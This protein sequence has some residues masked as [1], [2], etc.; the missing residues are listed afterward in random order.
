MGTIAVNNTAANRAIADTG[1]RAEEGRK[2]INAAFT[3]IGTAAGKIAKG[4]GIAGMAL[5]GAWIAAVEGTREYRTQMGMLD[6]AFQTAGHSSEAAKKTY[7]DLNAVLGDSAQ[8]TEAAQHLAK[9]T[10]NEKELQ[11]WTNI[12]TGVFATFGEALPIEGLTEAANETAKTGELTGSLV[13][14]LNWAGIGE[15]EFQKKLD[16]CTNEQQ[17]QKLIM[18]TLNGTYSKASEQYK[19]T[20]K[21]VLAANKAQEKLT[22][23][24]AE[25]G[26]VGEPILTV[27]KEKV[28]EMAT[29]AIP[30]LENFIQKVKDGAKWVKDNQDTIHTWV[31]VILGAGVAIGTFLLILNWGTIMTTAAN[32]IKVVRT[33]ILAMNAAML[34]NPIALIVAAIAGLVVGFIY[35]W[36]N[37]EGFR[38]FW[39]KTWEVIKQAASA[40]WD[41]IVLVFKLAWTG[42]KAYWSFA[43]G[44]YKGIWTGITKIFSVVKS[45]F[46][47]R[48]RDAWNG[49][50][51]IWNSTTSFFRGIWSKITGVFGNVG[52]WFRSK[53]AS[54][55]TSIKGVFS[56]WGS[57]FG[58]L[59]TKIKDKFSGLG[60]SLGNA[61]STSVKSA[62][63][64]VLGKVETAINKGIGLINS[65][66]D[67]VPG[68]FVGKVS[69]ITLPRLYRGGVLEKGQMGLLEGSG[70]EAVV[71]LEHNRAWL[72]RV[73]EDLHQIQQERPE[74]RVQNQDLT[75]VLDIL[76]Q[77]AQ[78][79]AKQQTLSVRL[80]SGVLVGAL[81]PAID[82]RLSD[83]MYHARRGNTR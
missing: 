49:V 44:F 79:L 36:N 12:A 24:M 13:D 74:N 21:D 76:S 35:L 28:A 56:G 10:D 14:A 72:S 27:I 34:A 82:A 78:M 32:A 26:R 1:Q 48:F 53:F 62:L 43:I 23:A 54:A 20:N 19:K 71:P 17:R 75:Q 25:L 42:I 59:W 31:G 30:H 33:A 73:A 9:L 64:K 65:A 81:T 60:T 22:D 67:L 68:D 47:A 61:M 70:A 66:I 38:A 52:G 46:T 15:E 11:T 6:A 4:I 16:K 58:G 29:A 50:K 37:V 8:A 55:W 40:T 18:D 77:I 41:A 51:N 57:F 39:M 5:G 80:D 2:R 45:W 7:S 3:A 83:R 63:N 69:K